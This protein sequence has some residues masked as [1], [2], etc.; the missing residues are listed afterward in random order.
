MEILTFLVWV[1]INAFT[2]KRNIDIKLFYFFLNQVEFF[3]IVFV[4]PQKRKKV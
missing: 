3:N 1:D 4:Y 2:L